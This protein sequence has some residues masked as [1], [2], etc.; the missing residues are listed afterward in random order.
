MEQMRTR[1]IDSPPA[2]LQLSVLGF[3][4]SSAVSPSILPPNDHHQNL[5]RV[6][7]ANLPFNETTKP[8]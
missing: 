5:F 8:V 1:G 4:F 3:A 7:T 6:T 2:Y